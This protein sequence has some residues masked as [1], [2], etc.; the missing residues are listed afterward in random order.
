[1]TRSFPMLHAEP[2]ADVV[3][4]ILSLLEYQSH[5]DLRLPCAVISATEVVH[6]TE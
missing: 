3:E 1:M 4:R 5:Q 6:L 2:H